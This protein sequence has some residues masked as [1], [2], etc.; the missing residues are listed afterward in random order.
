MPATPTSGG[1]QLG[2]VQPVEAAR[3]GLWSSSDPA[4]AAEH[5]ISGGRRPGRYVKVAMSSRLGSSLDP[6]GAGGHPYWWRAS[7]RGVPTS[8]SVD[9]WGVVG[10]RWWMRYKGDGRHEAWW[11]R[12]SITTLAQDVMF[13][14]EEIWAVIK[15]MSWDR[16]PSSN[17][18]IGLF[19]KRHGRLLKEIY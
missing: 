3:S 6:A 16:A 8:K 7:P 15:S 10:A 4:A 14:E 1:H 2:G 19:T 13:P 5:L 12:V 11:R 17:G 9:A 18:F